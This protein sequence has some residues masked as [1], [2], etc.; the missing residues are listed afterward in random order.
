MIHIVTANSIEIKS[1]KDSNNN[2]VIVHLH[3]EPF[4]VFNRPMTKYV[5]DIYYQ[6]GMDL[7]Q[8]YSEGME[9]NNSNGY[10][11]NPIP[12][13][14]ITSVL[15]EIV[16]KVKDLEPVDTDPDDDDEQ[17]SE[18]PEPAEE[19]AP[20]DVTTL[21]LACYPSLNAQIRK[22]LDS[23]FIDQDCDVRCLD[24][25]RYMKLTSV[26]KLVNSLKQTLNTE[27]I[28]PDDPI[29][30]AYSIYLSVIGAVG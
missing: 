25:Y 24:L 30:F 10:I 7:D 15:D 6:D 8:L 5:F 29:S 22:Y 3:T 26:E 20:P 1:I 11:Y 2:F 12:S 19:G 21:A 16:Q 23:E 18:Y 14:N 9:Y 4:K 27:F 17:S 13:P 28:Y